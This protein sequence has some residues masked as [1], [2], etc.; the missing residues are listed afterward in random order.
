M[1]GGAVGRHA[2][3]RQGCGATP[4]KLAPWA[5][6]AVGSPGLPPPLPPPPSNK[7][8]SRARLM[9]IGVERYAAL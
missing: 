6:K 8:C 3:E 2:E 1:E 7:S 5:C 9:A 4:G